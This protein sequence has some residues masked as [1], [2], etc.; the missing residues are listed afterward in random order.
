MP[1]RK[2]RIEMKEK[3]KQQENKKISELGQSLEH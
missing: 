1:A 3:E 2:P